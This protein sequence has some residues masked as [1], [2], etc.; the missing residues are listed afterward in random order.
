MNPAPLT[1]LTHAVLLQAQDDAIR[2][3]ARGRRPNLTPWV[4]TLV[5]A[6]TPM[7]ALAVRHGEK[8][9]ARELIAAIGKRRWGVRKKSLGQI[10]IAFDLVNPWIGEFIRDTTFNF[11]RSTLETAATEAWKAYQGLR[12]ELKAGTF[13]GDTAH[14]NRRPRNQHPGA[15]RPPVARG[16]V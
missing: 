16:G 15:G 1:R 13:E 11:A 7:I 12:A 9:K 10:Q 4:E 5:Q 2:Q 14:A 3:L 6:A 8:A